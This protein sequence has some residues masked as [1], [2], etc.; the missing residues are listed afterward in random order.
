[1]SAADKPR[2][3]KISA[4]MQVRIPRDLFDK[5][6]FGTEAEVVATSTGIEFRPVKS[7]GDKCADLLESLVEEGLSGKELLERF[8]AQANDAV[9]SVEYQVLEIDGD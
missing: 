2:V 3:A 6:G 4:Q 9:G 7:A 1:M 8:R 5:Y